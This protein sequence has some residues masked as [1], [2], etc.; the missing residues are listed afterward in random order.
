[1]VQGTRAVHKRVPLMGL[2]GTPT[3]SLLQ[4]SQQEEKRQKSERLQQQ[5]KHE[6][7]M[8]DMTAQCESNMNELQQLQVLPVHCPLLPQ[9]PPR[10]SAQGPET[11]HTGKNS[12]QTS[13]GWNGFKPAV[14]CN[15][16]QITSPSQARVTTSTLW[17]WGGATI[18]VLQA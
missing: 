6:N 16:G 9:F 17:E 7:Q 18:P 8:R 15:I 1:M 2:P 3:L 14:L 12:H 4:F 13:P 5:Q 11:L 10:Q